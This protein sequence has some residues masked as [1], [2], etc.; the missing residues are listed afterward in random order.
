MTLFV[1]H[2]HVARM[3]SEVEHGSRIR[4]V[5][6]FMLDSAA[7]VWDAQGREKFRMHISLFDM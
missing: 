1:L 6:A 5:H 2:A 4:K 3:S 7:L